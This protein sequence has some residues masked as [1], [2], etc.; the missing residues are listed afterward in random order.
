MLIH[1]E[2]GG[3]PPGGPIIGKSPTSHSTDD[4]Q[5]SPDGAS[6]T[7]HSSPLFKES[8]SKKSFSMTEFYNYV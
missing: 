6:A 5:A 2:G 8:T 4:V 7:F 3:G 1:F